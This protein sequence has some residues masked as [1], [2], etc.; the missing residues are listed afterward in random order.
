MA[1]AAAAATPAANMLRLVESIIS[2][3]LALP[4]VIAV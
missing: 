1:A 3:L 4:M 2:V